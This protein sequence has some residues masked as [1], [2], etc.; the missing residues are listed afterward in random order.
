MPSH[1][2]IDNRDQKLVD[3]INCIVE[4]SEAAH[5]AMGYLFISGFT[6][7]ERERFKL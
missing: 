1:D 5:F 4:S 6:R 3:K 7:C 2:I